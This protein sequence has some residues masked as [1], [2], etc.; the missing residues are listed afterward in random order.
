MLDSPI[1]S[2]QKSSLRTI[3][4]QS[5]GPSSHDKVDGFFEAVLA[6]E[7]LFANLSI[8]RNFL[9]IGCPIC[10]VS[11]GL[12]HSEGNM[13]RW[14]QRLDKSYLLAV[15]AL[16]GIGLV[17]V[18]SSSYIL[19]TESYGDGL[20]FIRRQAVF[21]LLGLMLLV[22]TANLS[23]RWLKRLGLLVW[24]SSVVGLCLTLVPGIGIKVGGAIRWLPLWG[25]LHIEPSEFLKIGL[26][27]VFANLLAWRHRWS[28]KVFWPVATLI[29]VG[30]LILL[31]LQPDFGSFV[32]CLM[33]LTGLLFVFGLS[34]KVIAGGGLAMLPAFYFLVMKVPYRRDRV[35]AFLDPWADPSQNGFQVIQSLLSFRSGGFWGRGIGQGQGKLY[36]LPEAHTD[37]TLAVLGE[38]LGLIGFLALL[39]LYGFIIYRTF[40]I[41]M[42]ARSDYPRALC[43]GIGLAFTLSVAVNIGVVLGMLPPKG[44]ALPF[45]SYGGSSLIATSLALGFVMNIQ[46]SQKRL[47]DLY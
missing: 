42:T 45:L 13:G 4:L 19:A 5:P 27:V 20:H 3:V 31:L 24:M 21:A 16:A 1:D 6:I 28:P 14:L 11:M 9:R 47:Q 8:S 22:G 10:L 44:L 26:P 12:S 29:L 30:P 7:S 17:Q 36:F 41:S 46:R 25:G 32:I 37:F 40:Q 34:W 38:E 43:L 15:F 35:L 2:V 23:F 33:V 39:S 18:Y